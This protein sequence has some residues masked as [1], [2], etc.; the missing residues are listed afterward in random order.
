MAR[1]LQPRFDNL[2]RRMFGSRR[3]LLDTVLGD[4]FPVF[5]L[6]AGRLEQAVLRH[7]WL[8]G[9]GWN[10]A[11][12][13]GN[14]NIVRITNPP[15]SGKLLIIEEVLAAGSDLNWGID[16]TAAV[17]GSATTERD[18]RL[19]GRTFA[20]LFSTVQAP[21]NT[22]L[23]NT[24]F[25]IR[26]IVLTPAMVLSPGFTFGLYSTALNVATF[27]Y[28]KWTEREVQPEELTA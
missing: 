23:T 15:A 18:T 26:G 24:G 5:D 10:L 25:A 12:S 22:L 4:V 11:A 7:E 17:G 21:G 9:F 6:Q 16:A 2:L 3:P 19:R 1:I 13:V 14:L 28:V 20:S 8:L 27:G